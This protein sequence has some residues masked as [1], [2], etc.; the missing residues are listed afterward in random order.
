MAPCPRSLYRPP[1]VSHHLPPPHRLLPIRPH[2]VLPVADSY[3]LPSLPVAGS[4]LR[5]LLA[6]T[7]SCPLPAS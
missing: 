4:V 2:Q 7:G 1:N 5:R 3:Q 6:K